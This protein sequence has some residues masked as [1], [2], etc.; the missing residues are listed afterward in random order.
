MANL[1]NSE[2]VRTGWQQYNCQAGITG[3][4]DVHMREM[5]AMT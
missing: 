2:Q 1:D 5:G 3:V 4:D